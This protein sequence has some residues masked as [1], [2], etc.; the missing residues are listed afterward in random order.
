MAEIH[1]GVW[2]IEWMNSI[3]EGEPQFKVGDT[4]IRGPRKK[5]K[6]HGRRLEQRYRRRDQPDEPPGISGS[7]GT[8]QGRGAATFF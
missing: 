5:E 6:K 7:R 1:F 8:Q 4:K 2:N 3:F